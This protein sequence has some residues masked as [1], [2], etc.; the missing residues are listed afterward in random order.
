MSAGFLRRDKW[1]RG[2][3]WDEKWGGTGR[4]F[5]RVNHT[6]NFLYGKNVFS[7][8]EKIKKAWRYKL[9]YTCKG[10]K[11]AGDALHCK[12]RPAIWSFV[13]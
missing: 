8:K 10:L 1:V 2:L 7:I 6:Q 12:Q 4:S 13:F 11:D 9:E 3:G 5:G